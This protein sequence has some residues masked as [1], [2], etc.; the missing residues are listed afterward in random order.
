MKL[1]LCTTGNAELYKYC[2]VNNIP[3]KKCG[4]LI[5]ATTDDQ[6][7]DLNEIMKRCLDNGV[8]DLNFLSKREITALEPEI[9]CQH[10]IFSPSTGVVDSHSLMSTIL[11]E[12]IRNDAEVGI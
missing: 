11:S 3:V 5:V 8:S 10:A 6:L 4:K 9:T 12:A 7:S 2:R 1:K